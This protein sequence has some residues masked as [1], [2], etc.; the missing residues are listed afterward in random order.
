MFKLIATKENARVGILKAGIS[1]ETPIF[2][3]VATKGSI[4]TLLPEEAWKEGTR[5]VIVNAL[6]IYIKAMNVVEKTGLHNFM[7]WKGIIFT[8]SGGFQSIKKFPSK[9]TDDGI[10]FT[11]PDG[12]KETFT[13]EKSIE[14]QKKLGSDF[15]FMLD[16]CPSYPYSDKRVKK[17]VERTMKWAKRSQGE[18]TFAILQGGIDNELRKKCIEE[19]KKLNFFGFAIGGLSIGEPKEKMHEMV[20]ITNSLLPEEKP[21]HLMGV[22]SPEDIITAIKNG[23]DIFDSAFPTRNAR[24]GSIFTSRGKINLGKKGVGGDAIDEECDCYTCRNFSLDY[25]K[26]LFKEK[27]PLA[28]RLATIHNIRYMNRLMERIREEIKNDGNLDSL[29]K[30]FGLVF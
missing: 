6:H 22:G 7:R 27:E 25:L 4:K 8:D 20:K 11:L 18:K 28:M 14:V 16:D 9:A 15:Y 23:V 19:I 21:R 3:P 26:Y 30:E 5:A 29:K 2:L 10:I 1:V 13:P 24:H 17:S 12:R